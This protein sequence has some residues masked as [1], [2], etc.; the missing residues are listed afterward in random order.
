MFKVLRYFAP[1]VSLDHERQ[2][3]TEIEV[4]NLLSVFIFRFETLPSFSGVSEAKTTSTRLEL[5][6]WQTFTDSPKNCIEMENL[7][8]CPGH[9]F[10][11]FAQIFSLSYVQTNSGG[12]KISK[13]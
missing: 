8:K 3:I 10:F 12:R 4:S 11:F 2:N 7:L 9:V 13:T 1:P 5:T 6:Q